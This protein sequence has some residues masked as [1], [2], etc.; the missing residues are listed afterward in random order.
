MCL[1]IGHHTSIIALQ[2]FLVNSNLMAMKVSG[3]YLKV[4]L[5]SGCQAAYLINN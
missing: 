3:E 4:Y 2:I 1:G 5:V